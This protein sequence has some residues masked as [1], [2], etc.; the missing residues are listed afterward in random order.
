ME[1]KELIEQYDRFIEQ[2]RTEAK[3]L[4]WLYN[5]FF[6]IE[7]ALLGGVF[8]GKVS[9]DYINIAQISGFFLALYWFIIIRKQ[10]LWRNDWVQRI[11]VIETELGY[12]EQ[13]QMW[14]PKNKPKLWADYIMGKKGM[15]RFLFVLPMCFGLV[16]VVLY[17]FY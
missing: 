10:R 6:I 16:W 11:Q 15:W 7:S 9:P 3:D 12:P 4:Y 17:L 1:R 13:F 5:F 2:V 14:K 8:A